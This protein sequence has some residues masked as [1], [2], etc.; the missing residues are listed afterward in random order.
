MNKILNL[1]L[2]RLIAAILIVAIHIY[3]FYSMNQ[4]LDY[5]FTHIMCRIGVPLFLMISGYFV[6]PI[7]LKNQKKLLDYTKNILKMYLFCILL[8]LPINI[9]AGYEFSL[10]NIIKD[11]L[12]NG[13]FYHLWYF[14]ALILGMYLLYFLLKKFD[15]KTVLIISL[16]LY[17]IGLFGDSYYYL[18]TQLS[19]NIYNNL[20][21]IFDYIRNGLFYV[22]IFLYMG[23]IL[24]IKK[25]NQT[26]SLY[27][28]IIFYIMM[29]IEGLILHNFNL[30]KHDSMYIMLL[31][32]MYYLFSYLVNFK[33]ENKNYRNIATDI[34]IFHPLFIIVIRFIGKIFNI[35]NIILYNNLI[36]YILVVAISLIFAIIINKIKKKK[37]PQTIKIWYH[38]NRYKL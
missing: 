22:P 7:A 25:P 10:T 20:F 34:Y 18:N 11:I 29:I 32:T 36:H 24:N 21:Q 19:L 14:P 3:P 31:P 35:E 5:I 15:K 30:Q 17:L 28:F 16:L 12:I 9:Y 23:Y 6:I 27:L 8:Y 38:I 1:D 33:T 26:K 13:T 37:L 4:T 2:S